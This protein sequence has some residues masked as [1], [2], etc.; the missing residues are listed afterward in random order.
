MDVPTSLTA[1]HTRVNKFNLHSV[2]SKERPL[3]WSAISSFEYD[4]AQWYDKYIMG[5]PTAQTE[6][7]KFGSAIGERLAKDPQFM[8]QVPRYPIFEHKMVALFGKIPL[9]GFVDS[10]KEKRGI[11]EYKTGK[12]AW[13][14]KRV[15]DHGQID[16]YLLLLWLTE[17]VPPEKV[18]CALVWLPTVDT[19]DFKIKLK[20]EDVHIFKT[21]RDMG[22]L[23]AF[24]ARIQKTWKDME[25]YV[26]LRQLDTSGKL[27]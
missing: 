2:Y 23:I 24:G 13:D 27:V 25:K 5:K 16:M 8:P 3:S 18:E 14:K 21:K 11:L 26:N 9:V 1:L 20:S 4:P 22:N 12:R 19:G 7:M 17:K 10:Y 6:E 15:R